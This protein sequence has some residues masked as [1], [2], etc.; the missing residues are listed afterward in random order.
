MI[1]FSFRAALVALGLTA[2]ISAAPAIA[3]D[4]DRFAGLLSATAVS[5]YRFR[6]ISQTDTGAAL[7]I[8][9][10][11][12]MK[13]TD[14]VTGYIGFWGSNV[15]FNNSANA[16]VDFLAGFRWS[17]DK[18][19]IDTGVI[20]YVYAGA[21]DSLNLDFT[22]FKA[23]AAYDFGFVIPSAGVYFSPQFQGSSGNAV[24]YTGGVSVP[25]PITQFEPKI[26]ANIGRQTIDKNANYGVPDYT[27]WNVGLFATFWG[28]TAGI[29]YVDTTIS[30]RECMGG[31]NW[32]EAGAVASLGYTFNF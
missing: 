13:L 23:T 17:F 4:A 10:E 3:A 8:G 20:R 19:S 14:M 25:L 29:Q 32:C 11:G 22:E 2:T 15:D 27:D 5:D 12:A 21:Q 7:Q 24:Y 1:K 16:E 6:G 18:L 31:V 30:K 9:G 26:V 28:F